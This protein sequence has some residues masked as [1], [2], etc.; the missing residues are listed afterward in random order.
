MHEYAEKIVVTG[1]AGF[2]GSHLVDRLLAD[3]RAE[4]VVLDNLSSGRLAHLARYRSEPRLRFVDADTRNQGAVSAALRGADIV[5]HLAARPCGVGA[6]EDIDSLFTT[7]VVGTF[8]V[9]QAATRQRVQHVVFAS[10]H[11]VYG[12]PIAL[13]VEESHPL[14]AVDCD[15][16]S[17]VAAE[18]FCRAFRRKFGLHTTVLRLAHVYGPRDSGRVVPLL[19]QQATGGQDLCVNG[20][21]Q[22]IDLVWVAQ[23]VEAL[24]RAAAVDEPVPPINVAS[25]TGTR[26]LD[27]ARRIA[28]LTKSRGQI[29]V[30]P[31][32]AV[33]I[34][35]FIASIDRMTQLLQIQPPLDPLVHLPSL[36]A[37]PV[38][39]AR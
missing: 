7:N 19:L 26:M 24:V 8:N 21:K 27:L 23:V 34:T 36:V 1:G 12:E 11:E 25:G 13:P 31:P 2:I 37:T 33:D 6:N 29:K 32:R 22:V 4:I 28:R 17:K 20:D 35:R 14:Q 39:V 5:Y 16:A 30:L 18:A 3:V 10:S 15:G 9:L 38:G